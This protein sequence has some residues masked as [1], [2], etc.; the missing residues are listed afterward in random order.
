[1]FCPFKPSNKTLYFY[2]DNMRKLK[3]VA[4]ER[5]KITYTQKYDSLQGM[6]S[7]KQDI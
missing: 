4:Q 2:F 1:V 6:G 3:K 7:N 5:T